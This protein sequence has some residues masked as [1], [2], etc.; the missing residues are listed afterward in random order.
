MTN[1]A[2]HALL[3]YRHTASLAATVTFIIGAMAPIGAKLG[4][5][6]RIGATRF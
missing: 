5:M 2:S 3:P 1:L 4:A 6:A